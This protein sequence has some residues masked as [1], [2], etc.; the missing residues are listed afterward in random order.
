MEGS[1]K[2]KQVMSLTDALDTVYSYNWRNPIY[3][4]VVSSLPEMT[5][6]EGYENLKPEYQLMVRKLIGDRYPTEADNA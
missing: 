6:L 5:P 1:D 2:M 4:Y 3:P